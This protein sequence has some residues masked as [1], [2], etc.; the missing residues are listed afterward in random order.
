MRSLT[1]SQGK[2]TGGVPVLRR[3][4]DATPICH[5]ASVIYTICGDNSKL[6]AWEVALRVLGKIACGHLVT[7]RC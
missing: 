5:L 6:A 4:R 3:S 1:S 7:G 2:K